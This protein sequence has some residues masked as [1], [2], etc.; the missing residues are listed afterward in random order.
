LPVHEKNRHRVFRFVQC[1]RI[2]R[3]GRRFR[4]HLT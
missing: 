3:G 1:E 4:L 2:F